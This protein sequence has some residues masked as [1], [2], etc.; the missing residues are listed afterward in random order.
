MLK[1]IVTKFKVDQDFMPKIVLRNHEL[2][3]GLLW[4]MLKEKKMRV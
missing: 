3:G 4:Q 2:R 1:A